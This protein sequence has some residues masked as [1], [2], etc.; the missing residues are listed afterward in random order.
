MTETQTFGMKT[1][2]DGKKFKKKELA[3]ISLTGDRM[4]IIEVFCNRIDILK[5]VTCAGNS[6]YPPY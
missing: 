1:R 3:V 6:F 2:G 4:F 5:R